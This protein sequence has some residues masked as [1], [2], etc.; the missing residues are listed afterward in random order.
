MGVPQIAQEVSLRR[1][2]NLWVDGSLRDS[3]WYRGVV[4]DI[5]SRFPTYRIA[6]IYVYACEETVIRR[7]RV[8]EETT[9]RHVPTAELQVR[10]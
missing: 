7:A 6:I 2:K 5:R 9:G 8:R 3:V 10:S 1:S 4:Q